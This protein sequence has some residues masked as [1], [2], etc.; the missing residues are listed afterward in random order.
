M[1][2]SAPLS[3]PHM[4]CLF[5]NIFENTPDSIRSLSQE[6]SIWLSSFLHLVSGRAILRHKEE[7]I[8]IYL[9]ENWQTRSLLIKVSETAQLSMWSSVYKHI[10]CRQTVLVQFLLQK[11]YSHTSSFILLTNLTRYLMTQFIERKINGIAFS[12]YV[13]GAVV[14]QQNK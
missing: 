13:Q 4:H 5:F 9:R 7:Y 10:F 2:I 8:W 3:Q 11:G 14:L 12:A 1:R 6:A